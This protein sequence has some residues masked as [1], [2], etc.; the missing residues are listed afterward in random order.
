MPPCHRLAQSQATHRG[1][2]A[3]AVAARADEEATMS[4]IGKEVEQDLEKDPKLKQDAEQEAK[5]QGDKLEEDV[6]KD[7]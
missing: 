1:R 7:L 5:K 3:R 4:D 2:P 6:K